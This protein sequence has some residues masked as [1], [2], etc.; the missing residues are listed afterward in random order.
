MKLAKHAFF[1]Y[2]ETIYPGQSLQGFIAELHKN[3]VPQTAQGKF[4]KKL[5]SLPLGSRFY[6][7]IAFGSLRGAKRSLVEKT[8]KAFFE[9]ELRDKNLPL[10]L[11]TMQT[12]FES[13]FRVSIVSGGCT[14]YLKHMLGFYFIDDVIA[15]SLV[16]D[17]KER[18]V[19]FPKKECLGV[20]K[21][22][23][24]ESRFKDQIIDWSA[25]V[26]YTDSESD[27]PLLRKVGKGFVV[28]SSSV[29]PSWAINKFDYVRVD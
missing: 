24:I 19:G 12:Y 29:A 22:K 14:E 11:R 25:A 20:Q 15:T 13:G 16:Y 23:F 7:K 1:D 18:L 28:G 4:K 21:I 17:T 8:G 26:F 5:L 10:M 6:K 9:D 3:I 2:C 27:L